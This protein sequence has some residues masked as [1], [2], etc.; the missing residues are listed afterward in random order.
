[1]K[2]HGFTL[3]ELIIVI[4][5]LGLLAVVAVPK[6]LNLQQ[7]SR[8]SVL[9]ATAASM[10]AT[11]EQVHAK[12]LVQDVKNGSVQLDELGISVLVYNGYVEGYWNGAWRYI[13]NIG[14]ETPFTSPSAVCTA[15]SLCG[16]G[17]QQ[18]AP[19]FPL[20]TNGAQGLILIW[21]QGLRLSD[22][23]YAYYYN[24]EDGTQPN[25]GVVS[26]GC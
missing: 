15:N 13:L 1:M 5:I 10:K 26:S 9:E 8:I 23:C 18:T 24:R 6:F 16:V 17:R 3:I 2:N 22:E 11:A 7:A 4:V 20:A 21:P 19:G 12:A 25:T 14:K